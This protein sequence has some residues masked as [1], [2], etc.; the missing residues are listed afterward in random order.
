MAVVPRLRPGGDALDSRFQGIF[1][2]GCHQGVRL[3]DNRQE[4]RW[5][6]F[7]RPQC[8]DIELEDCG[9]LLQELHHDSGVA[10]RMPEGHVLRRFSLPVP[11]CEQRSA[12]SDLLQ[13]FRL[14]PDQLH[15]DG[16]HLVRLRAVEE[17]RQRKMGLNLPRGDVDRA[18]APRGIRDPRLEI[19]RSSLFVNLEP[20]RL[21]VSRLEK[22]GMGYGRPLWFNPHPEPEAT[23]GRIRLTNHPVVKNA[24][25]RDWGHR[26]VSL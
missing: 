24:E 3:H 15:E 8:A 9:D 23:H 14:L 10:F 1:R 12:G 11:R 2:A 13:G 5:K 20:D 18:L 25:R 16:N 6:R 22:G 17:R 19:S 7:H 4:R 26:R 21:Y